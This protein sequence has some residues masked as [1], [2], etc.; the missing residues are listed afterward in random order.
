MLF[1]VKQNPTVQFDPTEIGFHDTGNAVQRDA[2]SGS[3][4]AEKTK[5]IGSGFEINMR[6]ETSEFFLNVHGETHFSEPPL[7]ILRFSK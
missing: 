6:F 4:C 1:T 7:L 5:G 2:F 3:R